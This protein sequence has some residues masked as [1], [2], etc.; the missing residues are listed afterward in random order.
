[1]YI[2]LT[3]RITRR[4]KYYCIP[5][6]AA[7]LRHNNAWFS[8]HY[9]IKYWSVCVSRRIN[10]LYLFSGILHEIKIY[11]FNRA[12]IQQIYYK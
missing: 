7:F 8:Q 11:Y 4:L 1:M 2:Q 6:A 9:N 12:K 3:W 10:P 5:Y